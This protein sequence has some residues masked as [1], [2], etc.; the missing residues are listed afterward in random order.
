MTTD[1]LARH[2]V[3]RA[4]KPALVEDL[5]DGHALTLSFAELHGR[6]DELAAR[7]SEVGAGKGTKVAWCGQNS[8]AVF[9][10]TCA[11]RRAGAVT[12]ALG[13][14]LTVPEIAY[15]LDDSGTEI[16]VADEARAPLVAR[17]AAEVPGARLLV[18][19]APDLRVTVSRLGPGGTGGRPVAGDL[20]GGGDIFYTSGTTGR[21]KGA[22]RM[23]V[24]DPSL[25]PLVPLIGYAEDDV[26]LT[27]G[28]LYHSGPARFA[29]MAHALGNTIVLQPKFDAE[30]WLRLVDR[31]GVSATFSA[32]TP[33]RSICALPAETKARYD[34]STM[35]RFVANAAPWSQALK[36]SYVADFAPASLWEVYGSA[37]FG[38]VTV[39]PPE[40]QLRKPGSCGLPVP[41]VEVMLL[42]ELGHKV[43]EP[44]AHGEVF[45]RSPS[46]FV[47]YHNAPERYEADRRG[48]F[49]TVGDIA[50]RDDDGYLYIADRKKDV[51]ISGGVNIYPA[52]VEAAIDLCPDVD[53]VAVVGLP[54]DHWGERVHAVVVPSRPGVTGADVVAFAGSRL[55]PYKIPR[56][57]TFTESLPKTE[58]GKV[59]KRELRALLARS[60]ERC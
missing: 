55:A 40:D 39:L 56:T 37:E 41:G 19:I 18:V 13:Y 48:E 8:A 23:A 11:T 31:Y 17:A 21:P 57:V 24:A 52:E 59:L 7:L 16:V 27:T 30:D 6:T 28:P 4:A 15:I 42:D 22:V 33:V 29:A 20:T 26:H 36:Q 49:H 58:S 25:S 34:R 12:V 5:S 54:D 32:P 50:Y 44:F 47:A 53:E 10:A 14:R 35:R 60:A 51:I 43:T 2:A 45:V 38:V 9:L 1:P 3:E 46:M